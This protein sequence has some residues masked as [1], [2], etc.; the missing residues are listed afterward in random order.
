MQFPVSWVISHF[1]PRAVSEGVMCWAD[2]VASKI[3]TRVLFG[4]DQGF[5]CTTSRL[6]LIRAVVDQLL[7]S[8][9]GQIALVKHRGYHSPAN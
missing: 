1:T 5:C 6:H 2:F 9:T 8:A 3:C 7:R 4:V